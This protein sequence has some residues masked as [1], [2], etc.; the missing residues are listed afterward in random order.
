MVSCHRDAP[1]NLVSRNVSHLCF[2]T[3][4][5]GSCRV[6]PRAG[7]LA[8]E[9]YEYQKDFSQI[10]GHEQAKQVLEIAAAGEHNLLM[11]GPP[12]CGKSLLAETFSFILLN[13]DKGSAA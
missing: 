13:Y 11:S 2:Y 3:L 12:G 7:A 1:K 10:I 5:E 9:T 8:E 4:W 6:L